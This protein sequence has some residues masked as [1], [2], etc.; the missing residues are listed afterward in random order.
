[1]YKDKRNAVCGPI[2]TVGG[3]EDFNVHRAESSVDYK[4]PTGWSEHT[5]IHTFKQNP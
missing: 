4:L 2:S 1:M 3:R 5:I